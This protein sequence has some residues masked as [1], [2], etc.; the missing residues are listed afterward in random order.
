MLKAV[1]Y[2]RFSSDNQRTESI[3][4][5]LRAIRKYCEDNKISL[6][7]VYRDEAKSAVTADRPAF[8]KMIA[9]SEEGGFDFVI[10]HKLDRFS[11]NR[12]DSIVF[13]AL[14]KKRGIKVISV[15]E[16]LNDSPESVI[17]ESVIEAMAQYYSMNLSRE[18]L[19]GLKENALHC[20]HTGG[21]PLFGYAVDPETQR[22]VIVEDEAIAVRYMYDAVL[23]GVGYSEILDYLRAGGFKTRNGN[24]FGKTTIYHMLQNEKYM[25]TYVF[26][27]HVGKDMKKRRAQKCSTDPEKVI[28]IPNG[29]P[30]IVSEETFMKVQEIIGKRSNKSGNEQ[31]KEVY[32]LAGKVRCGECG[33]AYCGSRKYSGRNKNLHVTYRCNNRSRKTAREC[34]NIEINRDRLER[35]V[36]DLLSD[37]I[38]D[39]KVIPDIIEK[40]ND[41]VSAAAAEKRDLIR[42]MEHRINVLESNIGN[43][44]NVI[45]QSGSQRLLEKLDDLER[46]QNDLLLKIEEEKKNIKEASVDEKI[47]KEAF[48][49]AKKMFESGELEDM[50]HLINLYLNEVVIYLDRIEVSINAL[51][52]Y[53]LPNDKTL[54]V[55]VTA[56]RK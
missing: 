28:R 42:S 13:K 47:I 15:S 39:E 17:L 52:G 7:R 9:D 29:V 21:K 14:L 20:M 49:R 12:K 27:M 30:A 26:T 25:G 53:T 35:Y 10:V 8:Q 6:I 2:A 54:D 56:E 3:D 34:R 23:R 19:K 55:D 43:I 31:A 40:Y 33:A 51:P 48:Y 38:F 16:P 11:R 46:E 45:S 5:Q 1:A 24:D 37:V 32:L 41:E 18:V 22:Y 4:A 36:L 44:L 50:R